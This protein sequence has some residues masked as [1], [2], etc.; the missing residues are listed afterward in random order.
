MYI[1]ELLDADEIPEFLNTV[2]NLNVDKDVVQSEFEKYFPHA[3]GILPGEITIYLHQAVYYLQI[4][5]DVYVANFLV[6]PAIRPLEGILKIALQENGFPIRKEDK[7]YDTFFVF[8]EK[9]FGYVI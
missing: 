1:I 5:G 3:L 9:E 6:E 8:K 7:D 2:H 4:N